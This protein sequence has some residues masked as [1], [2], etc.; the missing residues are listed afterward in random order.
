MELTK[1]KFGIIVINT[2]THSLPDVRIEL[3]KFMYQ[4]HK[5]LIS[6]GNKAAGMKVMMEHYGLSR[7]EIMAFGD[8]QNDTEMMNF[9]GLS[10]CMGNGTDDIKAISD[11]VTGKCSEDGIYDALKHFEII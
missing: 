9:A 8:S 10:V 2:F 4:V 1:I 5:R 11:Y 6:T 7:D 3:L